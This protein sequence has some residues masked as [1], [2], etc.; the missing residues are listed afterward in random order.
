MSTQRIYIIGTGVI[1][2]YHVKAIQNVEP[3]SELFAADPSA[4]AREKFAAAC[5]SAT[6]FES[7]EEMLAVPARETDIVVVST[8][9]FLH[10]PMIALGLK[11]GRH[12]LAEK[13]LLMNHK[14]IH[15]IQDLLGASDRKLVCCSTRFLPNPATLHIRE[16]IRKGDLGRVYG[17]KWMSRDLKNRTG[18][19]YQNGCWWFLDKSKNGGGCFMD[20]GPYDLATLHSI[21]QPVTVTVAQVAMAQSAVPAE[22]PEGTVFDVETQALIAL[23][24]ENAQGEKTRVFIDR[25]SSTYEAPV[26]QFS[27]TGARGSVEW[28]W[29]GLG[30]EIKLR[31]HTTGNPEPQESS[32]TT[33]GPLWYHNTPLGEMLKMLR[34]EPHHALSGADA[35]FCAALMRAIYDSAE[36]G[37]TVRLSL[38]DYSS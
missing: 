12:V 4:A 5:P 6:L 10:A 3:E 33:P 14:E 29:T 26:K 23:V 19:E 17:V 18:I 7:A 31:V 21:L 13:P 24:Y 16:M 37:S 1:A 30:E 35:L 27:L 2:G 15:D 36:T 25:A 20:W 22:I 11:S 9:P 38:S 34:G 8:P 32:I 28:D